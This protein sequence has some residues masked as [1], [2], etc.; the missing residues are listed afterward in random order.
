MRKTVKLGITL[1]MVAMLSIG[2]KGAEDND[3]TPTPTTEASAGSN[4]NEVA[5]EEPTLSEEA[6][7]MTQFAELKKG[8]T[9]AEIVIKDFGTITIKLFPKY[10]PKAVENFITL[11]K[12]GKYDGVSFHRIIDN[13][14][15]Q[16]GDPTGT[17]RGG[18]SI[19]NEP[20]EDEFTDKLQ[21]F[22]G[23]LCMANSGA[24]T[25]GSQF[26]IVDADAASVQEMKTLIEERYKNELSLVD[27]FKEAYGVSLSEKEIKEYLTYGGTPWLYK[28]HTVF[29]QVMDGFSVLD[30]VA[31]VPV[32][33]ET[34]APKTEI[35]M[36]TVKVYEYKGK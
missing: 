8:D 17:G 35:I 30:A 2:C 18:E 31:S 33:S 26:F 14:M 13:F 3:I 11:A 34:K 12:E 15:I 20:F 5:K 21:P 29:G 24:N 32:D 1:A 27:Y 9:V 4:T 22:R 6:K 23:A 28:K 36:E 25:N 10:A 7:K 16:G 19:W